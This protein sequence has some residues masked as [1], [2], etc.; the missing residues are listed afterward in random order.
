MGKADRPNE[1]EIKDAGGS[2]QSATLVK[3]SNKLPL[4]FQHQGHSR[5]VVSE[6]ILS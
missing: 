5:T 2:A 4:Y 1:A 6:E 3:M